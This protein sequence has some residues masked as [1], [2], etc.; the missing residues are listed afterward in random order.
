MESLLKKWDG[1]E[2]I[3]RFDNLTKAWIII[4]IHNTRLG[5]GTG[6]T[7]MK[8]YQNLQEALQDAMKLAEGMSYKYAVS[9]FPRG[10]AK[11]VIALPDK[12]D[13]TERPD[14]LR[15]YGKLVCQLGG[16]FETGPDV[17]TS[18]DDMDI[19]SET[20]DPYI[21]CRT[22]QKGGAGDSG[23]ATALGVFSGMQAVCEQLFN[24]PSLE[25]KRVLVQGAGSV[26]NPLIQLL[27]DAGAEVLFSDIDEAAI[28]HLQAKKGLKHI[29][30]DK[31]FDTPCDIFAPCALGGILNKNTIPRL[32]CL[33]VAGGANNQLAEPAD[34]E[35]LW[36]RQI[37]YAPDFAINIG[38]A[39]AIIG[40]ETMGWSRAEADKNVTSVRQ[41]LKHIFAIATAEGIN[42][43]VAA[44]RI[45]RSRLFEDQ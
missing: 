11:A 2:V 27:R 13:S 43:D 7:R 28:A 35:R 3:I 24:S 19:I 17:G 45:A 8:P 32:K 40:I 44:R 25:A 39:M 31:I 4:A 38:G 30:P 14:L 9:N 41:T 20:G 15:R 18:P 23:P 21:F 6:G 36:G 16:L 10:G 34:A 42:T 1:E 12:F 29:H 5:I 26:G 37:L 22:P 33:A